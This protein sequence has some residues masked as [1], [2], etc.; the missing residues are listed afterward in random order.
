MAKFEQEAINSKEVNVV[1]GH[2]QILQNAVYG[3]RTEL[4]DSMG[5]K[6]MEMMRINDTLVNDIHKQAG[7]MAESVLKST[8]ALPAE[9]Q[10]SFVAGIKHI[11]KADDVVYNAFLQKYEAHQ[12][13]TQSC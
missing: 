10:Q 8:L 13:R 2:E 1:K 5:D 11:A 4:G 6:G 12:M 9:Q 7:R 3:G